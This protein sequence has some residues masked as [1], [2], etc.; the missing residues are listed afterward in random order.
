MKSFRELADQAAEL[1]RAKR[2]GVRPP[3]AKTERNA[4]IVWMR[5]IGV[6]VSHIARVHDIT[7]VRVRAI[8]RRAARSYA[9]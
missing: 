1:R 4:E 9:K 6:P 8:V 5:S 2:T 3:N 7:D